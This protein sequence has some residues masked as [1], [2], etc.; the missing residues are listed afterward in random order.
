MDSPYVQGS[1]LVE[2]WEI[3]PC[4]LPFQHLFILLLCECTPK[5]LDRL[6]TT[7]YHSQ[8]IAVQAMRMRCFSRANPCSPFSKV[9]RGSLEEMDTQEASSSS[10]WLW[11]WLALTILHEGLPVPQPTDWR[12]LW[13]QPFLCPVTLRQCGG[14]YDT[15]QR[16]L[17]EACSWKHPAQLE[18]LFVLPRPITFVSPCKIC[19]FKSP[20]S[21]Y[22]SKNLPGW[23]LPLQFQ[24]SLR[25]MFHT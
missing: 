23:H 2:Y 15:K 21:C 1:G 22:T 16:G 17:R 19:S 13:A 18:S 24:C 5:V 12:A 25:P 20:S 8:K 10:W 3:A 14:I 4:K 11:K 9:T 6:N 7:C